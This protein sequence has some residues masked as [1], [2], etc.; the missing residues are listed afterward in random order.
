VYHYTKLTTAIEH[1]LPKMSLR[2]NN[3]HRMNDPK[4]NQPWSFAGRNIDYQGSYPETYSDLTHIDH[5]YKLG[6]E[7]KASC[8]ILCFVKDNPVN[9]YL[10]E[11]MWAHYAENHRGICLE[12]DL[13]SFIQENI[14]I[15]G[16]FRFEE[17]LYGEHERLF[18]SWER[19]LS[20]D[21]NIVRFVQA[22]YKDLFLKK[23]TYW[24]RENEQRIVIFEQSQKFLSIKNSLSAIYFGLQI[25]NSYRPSID[26]L[27]NDEQTKLFNLYYEGNR[28]KVMQTTKGDS[29]PFI[30]RKY[31][32]SN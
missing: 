24:E 22:R 27:I 11:I 3:L 31:I 16:Q 25:P 23:S 2:T 15:L 30:T 10:N 21:Q 4:E 8:Q 14:S 29:R 13:D 9:G 6:D 12:I 26:S 19:E 17:V 7:I 18:F 5:Q 32:N 20:K 1:I 28:I